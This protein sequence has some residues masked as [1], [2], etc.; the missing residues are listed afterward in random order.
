MKHLLFYLFALLLPS[1]MPAQEAHTHADGSTHAAH[2]DETAKTSTKTANN[3][4]KP[5]ADHFTVY[6]ESDRY[7]LTLYYPELIA[8]EASHLTLFI[9]DFKTNRP[10]E[11]AEL[12]ISVMENPQIVFEVHRQEFVA[13]DSI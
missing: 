8:G 9:A 11:K 13:A 12:K 1:T 3:A 10:I 6:G 2:D 7:E 5:D 4:A